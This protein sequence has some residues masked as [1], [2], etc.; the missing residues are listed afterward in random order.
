MGNGVKEIHVKNT[1]RQISTE[2][3]YIL[4]KGIDQQS[5]R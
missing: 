4:Q 2:Y 1:D 5:Y 3:C